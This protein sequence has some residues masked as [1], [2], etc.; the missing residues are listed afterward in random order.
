M[1]NSSEKIKQTIFFSS[2]NTPEMT[3][4]TKKQTKYH[5]CKKEMISAKIVASNCL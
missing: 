5:F 3:V 1:K 4:V 2:L